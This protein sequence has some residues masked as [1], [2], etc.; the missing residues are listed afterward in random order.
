MYEQLDEL[1]GRRLRQETRSNKI[2]YI[3]FLP[4]FGL[5]FSVHPA[6]V[7]YFS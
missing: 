6:T 5:L 7:G 4:Y 3:F 1:R 2:K